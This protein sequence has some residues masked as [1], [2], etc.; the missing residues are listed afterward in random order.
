MLGARVVFPS[1]SMRYEN[2][3][4][5]NE[6]NII[7]LPSPPPPPQTPTFFSPPPKSSPPSVKNTA[8]EEGRP[9][10]SKILPVVV[11][12]ALVAATAFVTVA[13]CL[14][15]RRKTGKK[16][17][18]EDEIGSAESLQISLG[19]IRAAT[20]NFS[21]SNRL[22]G[23]GF[24]NVYKGKLSNGQ[25][26]AV[27]R[28]SKDSEQGDLQFKNEVLLVAK[29]QH[30]NLVRLLGFCLEG[31]ERLLIYEFVPNKSLEHFLF[32]PI[33]RT[34]LDWATRYKIIEGIAR[35]LLYLHED[36]RLL[37]IHRDLN[38]SNILLDEEMNPKISDFGMARLFMP[39]QTQGDTTK[40]VGTYGYMAP[41]YLLHGKFSIKTDVFSFGVLILEIISGQKMSSFCNEQNG[42]SLL[43]FAWRNWLEGTALNLMDPMMPRVCTTEVMRCV[44]IALLCVQENVT[45]RPIMSAV[46]LMLSSSSITL[47]MPSRP[48]FLMQT[49]MDLKTPPVEQ[50]HGAN[51]SDSSSHVVGMESANELSLSEMDPR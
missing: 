19:T 7:G 17:A 47:Q 24:G 41:E 38:A 1:C 8:K 50:N 16:V 46:V 5:Y 28:L 22:G 32:D 25:E 35:G 12:L 4:F 51:E 48:A 33:K 3:L 34:Y 39:D 45:H 27:K 18:R 14:W 6:T 20:N 11:V 26:V 2:Y 10:Q 13:Y 43:G 31:I 36:S 40:I 42:E 29:L 49:D 21:D 44:N 15:T 9:K 23:G 30:R 37:I